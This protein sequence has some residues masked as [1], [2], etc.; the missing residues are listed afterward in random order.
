RTI[1]REQQCWIQLQITDRPASRVAADAGARE[2]RRAERAGALVRV[3]WSAH[4]A[5]GQSATGVD[6]CEIVVLALSDGRALRIADVVDVGA[7]ALAGVRVADDIH[8]GATDGAV[9]VAEHRAVDDVA[10]RAR[11]TR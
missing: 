8:L 6:A 9:A 5:V 10:F 11:S 1:R 7:A 3:R 2:L 4:R